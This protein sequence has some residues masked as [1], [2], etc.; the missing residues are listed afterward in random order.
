MTWTSTRVGLWINVE[1]NIGIVSACLPILRPIFATKYPSSP[2]SRLNR[3]LKSLTNSSWYDSLGR[4][5]DPEKGVQDYEPS[6]TASPVIEPFSI[7][8]QPY[9]PSCLTG[10]RS[11]SIG[12]DQ[13]P[14]RQKARNPFSPSTRSKPSPKERQDSQFSIVPQGLK[15]NHPA[16]MRK[17]ST[18][19][20]RSSKEKRKRSRSSPKELQASQF[21]TLP[22]SLIPPYHADMHR[23]SIASMRSPNERQKAH[24][25][26][27][28]A[29]VNQLPE[30]DYEQER[31]EE[32][33]K[34]KE[35]LLQRRRAIDQR[36][37]ETFS[38][39]AISNEMP[40][41][42]DLDQSLKA[43]QRIPVS[44]YSAAAHQ[45]PNVHGEHL[46]G[47]DERPLWKD[48]TQQQEPE[49]DQ[50]PPKVPAKE[51]SWLESPGKERS[52]HSSK[53]TKPSSIAKAP[54]THPPPTQT[55]TTSQSSD[56]AVGNRVYDPTVSEQPGNGNSEDWKSIMLQRS[57]DPARPPH[58]PT[59]RRET[60]SVQRHSHP[61][62][63]ARRA[64]LSWYTA[65]AAHIPD[66]DPSDSEAEAAR[67]QLK[68][69]LQRRRRELD[70]S[71]PPPAV[72][73]KDWEGE[74]RPRGDEGVWEVRQRERDREEGKGRSS[75]RERG[76]WGQLLLDRWNLMPSIRFWDRES[77]IPGVRG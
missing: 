10:P 69:E 28:S 19:S 60:R 2:A 33:Q 68:K 14:Q 57:K 20:V 55:H 47:H 18:T 52:S 56:S 48:T 46:D 49:P 15:S 43:K 62:K 53:E 11:P 63:Q 75:G 58:K 66:H 16:D 4:S 24:M 23:P 8:K 7:F 9:P 64:P 73:P 1:C 59:L 40:K 51:E 41:E 25:S 50:P 22:Q 13:S 74:R 45:T 76:S 27:Y 35:K 31:H 38:K 54:A 21:S 39:E 36:P 71:P 61:R 32:R 65:A 26:W 44:R 12:S 30:V 67:Q 3:L 34:L 72:P 77:L 29:A 37:P 5:S 42:T 70:A 6:N 17:P